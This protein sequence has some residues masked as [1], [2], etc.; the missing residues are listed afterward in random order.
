M[1]KKKG[2]KKKGKGRKDLKAGLQVLH[3]THQLKNLHVAPRLMVFIDQSYL[4]YCRRE[5]D[6]TI[7][8]LDL[9]D[10]LTLDTG[11]KYALQRVILYGSINESLDPQKVAGQEKFYQMVSKYPK[12]D[13]QLFPIRLRRNQNG[14]VIGKA[15]KC[16]DC[17]IAT[18]LVKYALLGAYDTAILI[19]GDE[20]LVP[21]VREV[22]DQGLEVIVAAF[23]D[24]YSDKL[25]SEALGFISMTK[26]QPAFTQL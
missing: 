13:V 16:V 19:S 23:D 22:V 26:N 25:R 7:N 14:E 6:I 21:P 11:V 20:D 8:Y 9:A 10:F 17:A 2:H 15:E 24:T 12:F 5:K 1:G 4:Y 3:E 18:G